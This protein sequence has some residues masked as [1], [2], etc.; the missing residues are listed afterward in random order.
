M[1]QPFV[2]ARSKSAFTQSESETMT[3]LVTSRQKCGPLQLSGLLCQGR[4]FVRSWDSAWLHHSAAAA[5]SASA[6]VPCQ[7]I[8]C[9]C[10]HFALGW[11][12]TLWEALCAHAWLPN[13]S[14]P[15]AEDVRRNIRSKAIGEAETSQDKKQ[16]GLHQDASFYGR[17]MSCRGKLITFG[18][19]L[20]RCKLVSSTALY[21]VFL[22]SDF[23][24]L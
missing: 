7:A 9:H 11:G 14:V 18:A 19:A 21:K 6:P 17:G 4:V 13:P 10:Q 3:N 5:A 12:H 23:S 15:S 2:Q 8:A 1:D 20:P 24:L 22:G 16:N